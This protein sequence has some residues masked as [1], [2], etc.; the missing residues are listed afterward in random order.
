MK[1]NFS[2][3]RQKKNK[4]R[5][6]TFFKYS[7]CLEGILI[8]SLI[9][10]SGLSVFFC[11]KKE[12]AGQMGP[13]NS[14][15]LKANYRILNY[16]L[17]TNRIDFI[18]DLKTPVIENDL[19]KTVFLFKFAEEFIAKKKIRELGEVIAK[20]N[21]PY[22][23]VQTYKNEL[24]LHY[25]YLTRQFQ[26]Y[27]KTFSASPSQKNEFLLYQIYCLL[28]VKKSDDAF[29]RFKNLFLPARLKSSNRF[30]HLP[31]SIFF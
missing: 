25:Y 23:F 22:P 26:E 24:L 15:Q 14:S 17:R 19:V 6:V 1:V 3:S 11:E 4:K 8:F 31:L 18:E 16:F 7:L 30:C 12:D 9:I 21:H 27:I 29:I 13:Y 28:N 20:I 5:Q 2:A 10:S